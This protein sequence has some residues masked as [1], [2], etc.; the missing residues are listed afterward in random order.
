[1]NQEKLRA[2]FADEA[3]VKELF[4]LEEPEDVQ[5]KLAERGIEMSLDE[6]KAIPQAFAAAQKQ[7]G[8][9]ELSEDD[10]ENVAGGGMLADIWEYAKEGIK[11][12]TSW[13]W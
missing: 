13:R 11:V 6:I 5:K 1:M 7:E 9:G 10:L 8:G 3:F 12:W 2:A 4:A